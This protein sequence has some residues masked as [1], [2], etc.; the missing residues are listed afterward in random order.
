MDMDTAAA[1]APQKRKVGRP[2]NSDKGKDRATV[3]Q[4]KSATPSKAEGSAHA[5]VSS[6][7]KGKEK[8]SDKVTVSGPAGRDRKRSIKNDQAERRRQRDAKF[9]ADTGNYGAV[10]QFC[11]TPSLL[12]FSML[13]VNKPHAERSYMV[14]C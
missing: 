9:D 7:K 13:L 14:L 12:P 6:S 5:H 2:R 11:P 3:P 4:A 10:C 8:A 1:A